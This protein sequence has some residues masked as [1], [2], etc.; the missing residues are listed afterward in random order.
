MGNGKT[1]KA[2]TGRPNPARAPGLKPI[3]FLLDPSSESDPDFSKHIS[4]LESAPSDFIKMWVIGHVQNVLVKNDKSS[5][6]KIFK[7]NYE[8]CLIEP[9][10]R[11]IGGKTLYPWAGLYRKIKGQELK[12]QFFFSTISLVGLDKQNLF[13]KYNI[14]DRSSGS[15]GNGFVLDERKTEIF[16]PYEIV[17]GSGSFIEHMFEYHVIKIPIESL[18]DKNV[19]G[20][21]EYWEAIVFHNSESDKIKT[22]RD[23]VIT[24]QA[25]PDNFNDVKQILKTIRGKYVIGYKAD[26][27]SYYDIVL[28]PG[29]TAFIDENDNRTSNYSSLPFCVYDRY[30]SPPQAPAATRKGFKYIIDETPTAKTERGPFWLESDF[31]NSSRSGKLKLKAKVKLYKME[32]ADSAEKKLPFAVQNQPPATDLDFFRIF[33]TEDFHK[34]FTSSKMKEKGVLNALNLEMIDHNYPDSVLKNFYFGYGNDWNECLLDALKK[35]AL[36]WKF[37]VRSEFDD[38]TKSELA[39]KSLKL[40]T[41]IKFSFDTRT[42]AFSESLA[43]LHVYSQIKCWWEGL[44]EDDRVNLLNCNYITVQGFASEMGGETVN[45]P[46]RRNRAWKTAQSLWLLL[47]NEFKKS[48]QKKSLLSPVEGKQFVPQ[49]IDPKDRLNVPIFHW[50]VPGPPSH[51]FLTPSTGIQVMLTKD[52][53]IVEKAIKRHFQRFPDDDPNHRVAIVSFVQMI[54]A[55]V[56]QYLKEEIRLVTASPIGAYRVVHY[57][58]PAGAEPNKMLVY[59]LK[60]RWK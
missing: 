5:A 50:G 45:A 59:I 40:S 53:K 60:P 24:N 28:F 1:R 48:P 14:P 52:K 56:E 54:P 4:D 57:H 42:D 30:Q 38:L 15:G 17:G 22:F 8:G 7:T 9:K 39:T 29:N 55:Y 10:K 6:L 44:G 37:S 18:S 43:P 12:Y 11:K 51:F 58:K 23:C 26:V 36:Y 13:N 49:K 20:S 32:E 33:D 19:L 16:R 2:R 3:I 27:L 46:L 41:N 35:A 21:L 25:S 31:M 34:L 47:K